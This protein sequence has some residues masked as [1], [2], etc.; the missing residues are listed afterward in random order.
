MI[1]RL[2]V[3][4]LLAGGVFA[5]MATGGK[6]PD[7][8]LPSVDG[9]NVHL[10]DFAGK[11]VVLEWTNPECPF[12]QK[13]YRDGDMQALQK[14][15]TDKGVIWLSI[16]STNP[17]HPNYMTPAQAD[18]RAR[19]M[20][21]HATAVLQDADGRVGKVYGAKSTPHMFII[22]PRGVLVYQG[23]ID[24]QPSPN[25]SPKQ[26]KNYVRAALDEVLAGKPVSEATTKQYGC[27]V[28]YAD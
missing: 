11:T 5:D 4:L 18:A 17:Q 16:N 12:V 28:K 27:G 3:F 20:H 10:A 7:F 8:T 23:A 24:N 22:D 1:H 14:E 21:V 25:G 2:L 13:H 6:V 9:K 19:Q 15:F 26:A